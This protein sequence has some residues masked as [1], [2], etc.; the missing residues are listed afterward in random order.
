MIIIPDIHGRDFWEKPV[1]ENLKKE[2][3]V[4]LGDYLDPYGYEGIAP[5]E[6][7]PRFENIIALKKENPDDVTLLLG[8]HDL[9]YVHEDLLGGRFDYEN[10]YRNKQAIMDNSNLFQLTYETTVAGRKYLFTHAGVHMGWI[11]KN[12]Q[13]LGKTEPEQ[14]GRKLNDYWWNRGYWPRLFTILADIPYSR[15]GPCRYGSPVWAGIEDWADDESYEIPDIY[16]IFGH[17]QQVVDP[18][19][20]KHF[21]C[22]DC[23]KAFRLTEEGIIIPCNE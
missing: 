6:V 14:V 23:R 7:F 22:L 5:W 17:S 1:K 3:I 15:W 12:R 20:G 8:N 16:Q 13:Y 11:E 19:I 9:H 10:C 2:H 21:A 18:V 4:F